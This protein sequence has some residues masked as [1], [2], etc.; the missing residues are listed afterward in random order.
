M[1][2]LEL[3]GSL[4]QPKDRGADWL[5]GS[6]Y[7]LRYHEL[8]EQFKPRVIGEIGVRFGYSSWCL[9]H[10]A[11]AQRV[12]GWD[13]QSYEPGCLAVASRNL[14]AYSPV[15]SACDSQQTD[16]LSCPEPI[17]LFHVDGD[18]TEAGALHDLIL[19]SRLVR[20]GG[21]VLVDDTDHCPGVKVA[22]EGFCRDRSLPVSYRPTLRGLAV[23]LI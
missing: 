7:Y 15:L 20:P 3:L 8:G 17:D 22:V 19:A 11:G 16:A 10:G 23:I 14:A 18:H 13:N 12:Y 9:A 1:T 2:D 5:S 21:V 6:N 4:V